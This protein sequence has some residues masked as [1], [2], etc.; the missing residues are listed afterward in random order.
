MKVRDTFDKTFYDRYY[1]RP[2]TAVVS[3]NDILKR[4]RFVLAYLDYLGVPVRSALDAGCGL[5]LWCDA[6]H[7]LDKSIEYTGIEVSEYLCLEMGWQQSTIANFKTR[8]KYDLVICQDVMQYIDD[9]ESVQSIR[10]LSRI[11]RGVLYFDVPT[12]E[13]IRDGFLDETRT[14]REIHLRGAEWYKTQLSKYFI[15]AG[16]GVFVPKQSDTV[17]L[18]LE[19]S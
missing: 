17:V 10:K 2:S 14:D 9:R 13:D 11:C 19:R 3:S 5:G 4:A 1:L 7:R 6:L 18:A 16:G 12:R 15:S 8:R